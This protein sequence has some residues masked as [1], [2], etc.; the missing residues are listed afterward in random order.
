MFTK[1][2][3]NLK[4]QNGFDAES[5]KFAQDTTLIPNLPQNSQPPKRR[6]SQVTYLNQGTLHGD[7]DNLVVGL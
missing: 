2:L 5:P 4:G 6:W 7:G 1:F 3:S